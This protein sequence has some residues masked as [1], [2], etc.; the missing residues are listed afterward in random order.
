MQTGKVVGE[1]KTVG[2]LKK[3]LE[4]LPDKMTI[5]G[6]FDEPG[7]QLLRWS[8]NGKADYIEIMDLEE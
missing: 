5:K 4:G 6:S 2:Q 7:C 1:A 8:D 3:A